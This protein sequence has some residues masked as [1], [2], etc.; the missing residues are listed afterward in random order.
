MGN[1]IRVSERQTAIPEKKNGTDMMAE[2]RR[3][4]YTVC[5]AKE[6]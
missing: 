1:G 4:L 5:A 3:K 6:V 2:K